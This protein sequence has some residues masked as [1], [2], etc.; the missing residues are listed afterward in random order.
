MLEEALQCD[1]QWVNMVPLVSFVSVR[2][3]RAA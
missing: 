1:M 3:M 2:G